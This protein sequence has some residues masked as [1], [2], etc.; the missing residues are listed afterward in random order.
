[1][2]VM[3]MSSADIVIIAYIY[4]YIYIYVY[5]YTYTQ[6]THTFLYT[7]YIY[8]VIISNWHIPAFNIPPDYHLFQFS[9]FAL[10][11]AWSGRWFRFTIRVHRWHWCCSHLGCSKTGL[12][13]TCRNCVRYPLLGEASPNDNRASVGAIFCVCRMFYSH[14]VSCQLE[15]EINAIYDLVVALKNGALIFSLI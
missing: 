4:I 2:I 10:F 3:Y 11:S 15:A 7:V 12:L 14:C 1:M 13:N 5:I 6:Y 8:C 9:A